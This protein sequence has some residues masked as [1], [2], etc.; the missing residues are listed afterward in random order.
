MLEKNGTEKGI[1]PKDDI[2]DRIMGLPLFRLFWKP[3]R[4]YKD[5][6]LYLFFGVLTTLINIAAFNLLSNDAVGMN[7]HAA[8]VIAWI[9]SVAFAYVTNRTWVFKEHAFGAKGIARE[10]I[11]FA[12]GR[13]ATL[14]FEEAMLF[15]FVTWLDFGKLLIKIIAAV[16][17][18][19]L[20]Y[21]I[22]KL[23]VFRRSCGD[24]NRIESKEGDKG[25]SE[26]KGNA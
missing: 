24:E 10:I 4:R 3:Y 20:N 17:V 11:S 5:V 2:F 26:K 21:V 16:G 14:G 8:N 13:L 6:L 25:S 18:V 22:S 12:G 23:F 7:I 1:Q 19:I 15:V 9:L